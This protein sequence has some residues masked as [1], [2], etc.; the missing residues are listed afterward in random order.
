MRWVRWVYEH[1]V[2]LGL[3]V[4]GCRSAG[5][6]RWVRWVR[7]HCLWTCRL[8][9]SVRRCNSK[10]LMCRKTR[11]DVAAV[12]PSPLRLADIAPEYAGI[13]LALTNSTATLCGI[14]AP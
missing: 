6:V 12:V 2:C 10:R 3:S 14:V 4:C 13:I 7:L 5:L 9:L 11:F 8:G 1:A